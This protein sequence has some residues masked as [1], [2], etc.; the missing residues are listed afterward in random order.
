[1]DDGNVQLGLPF[2]FS[3]CEQDFDAVFV[4]ANG[5]LTFGA[6][7]PDF[8]ES[9]ADMLDG[10][11]RIAGVWDDLNPSAGGSVYFTTT[12]NTFNVT[13]EDVP[14]WFASGS[15]TFSIELK[16]DANQ[17]TVDYDNIEVA[18]GLTGVS[19]GAA[20]TGGVEAETELV[21]V[22]VKRTINYN[23]QTAVYE[24]FSD[25]DNDLD[26]YSLTFNTVK[27]NLLDDVF[28]PNDSP[29]AATAISFPFN[30]AANSSY[31][32]ISPAAADIDW[33]TFYGRS[34]QTLVA[35]I[36][37]GQIDSVL[38]VFDSAG[39]L[40]AANDDANG[41]LSAVQATLPAD[42]TYFMAVTFCCDFDFDG[43][44]PGQG[45]PFDEGRYVIDAQLYDGVPIFLGDDASE[46]I[47]LG[48]SFPFQGASY[49]SVFVNSNGNLTFG[50]GDT[51]FTESV[52][53]FLDEN[54]RI[55]PLWDDLSPNQGGIIL[56]NGDASSFSVSFSDVPQFLAGDSNNFTVTL[57]PDG[58]VSIEY[59][60]VASADAI[61]GVTEGNFAAD[62]GETDLSAGGPFSVVGTTYEQFTAGDAFDLDA[63]TL[64]FEP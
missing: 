10:P 45:L 22:P 60:A 13:W 12:K 36:T 54:P 25:G 21:T 1:M 35:E 15:N 24:L 61:V 20:V 42:D 55:A 39:N 30:T 33:F 37:R 46:E 14:E 28:E 56:Y 52:G 43:V 38:G 7:D 29:A 53:E 19:C 27:H 2:T 31:T 17:V 59:G 11:P 34:G 4:N 62:P 6:G 26:G 3:I 58:T 49:S 8:S 40:V 5:S 51:D 63:M 57:L 48:F 32:E 23:G 64:D 47:T 18:D 16:K 41:L 9:A 44:D 50:G